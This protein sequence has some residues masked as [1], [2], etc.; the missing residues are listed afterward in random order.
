MRRYPLIISG[1]IAQDKNF[2]LEIKPQVH[3]LVQSQ[4]ALVQRFLSEINQE[5]REE[6]TPSRTTTAWYTLLLQVQRAA[7]RNKAFYKLMQDSSLKKLLLDMEGIY[8]RDKRMHEL[9]DNLFYVVEE[10]QKSVTSCE[11]GRELLSRNDRNLFVVESLD[12]LLRRVDEDESLNDQEKAK[13]KTLETNLFMDKSEKLHNINQL[14]RAYTLFQNDKEYVAI[15]NRVVIVDELTRRQMPVL[16]FRMGCTRPGS[17]GKRRH[18]SG[19]PDLCH[20]HPAKL[21]PHV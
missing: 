20:H 15:D 9:D 14:L 13:R 3:Q 2:Y 21:F 17:Q 10:R 5:L 8:L 12:E 1:P 11:K 16:A 6:T 18:R 19:H 4:N 7:P